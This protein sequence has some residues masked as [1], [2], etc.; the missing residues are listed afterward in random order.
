[1]TLLYDMSIAV[2]CRAEETARDCSS[3]GIYESVERSTEMLH[4]RIVVVF[5]CKV[6]LV[7]RRRFPFSS[8]IVIL[9]SFS[10]TYIFSFMDHVDLAY[11]IT[12]KRTKYLN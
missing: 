5:G 4:L 12:F 6:V 3:K 8:A 2:Q 7:Q 1:M 9:L 10:A 11:S